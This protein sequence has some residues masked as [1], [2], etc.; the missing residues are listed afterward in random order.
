MSR[1][2]SRGPRSRVGAE[3]FG[4]PTNADLI[5]DRPSFYAVTNYTAGTVLFVASIRNAASF[6]SRGFTFSGWARVS[7]FAKVTDGDDTASTCNFVSTSM[8]GGDAAPSTSVTISVNYSGPISGTITATISGVVDVAPGVEILGR[9]SAANDSGGSMEPRMRFGLAW[10]KGLFSGGY[11]GARVVGTEDLI[12]FA[13]CGELTTW[14][15]NSRQGT[16]SCGVTLHDT[17]TLSAGAARDY[18]FVAVAGTQPTTS[19]DP[20]AWIAAHANDFTV[21]ITSRTGSSTGAMGNLAFSLKTAIATTT[22]REIICNTKRFMRVK[23]WQKVSGE[24]HL[25]V[26]FHLDFWLNGSDTP[27]D[28]EFTALPKM[29][30]VTP[31]PFGVTQTKER[32]TYT[33]TFKYGSTTLDTRSS[34]AHYYSGWWASLRSADD[35]HHARKH[36]IQLSDNTVVKPKLCRPVYDASTLK[37][38]M[39]VRVIPPVRLGIAYSGLNSSANLTYTPLTAQGAQAALDA[40]GPSS[41]RGIVTDEECRLIS[42]QGLSATIAK[43]SWRRARVMGQADLA[44]PYHNLDHRTASGVNGGTDTT[45]RHIPMPFRKTAVVGSQS[46]AGLAT[47]IVFS[48]VAYEELSGLTSLPYTAPVGGTGPWSL[49]IN[50]SHA[51][52]YAGAIAF[53][54]GETYLADATVSQCMA[55]VFKARFNS[56]NTDRYGFYTNTARGTAVGE[57]TSGATNRWGQHI[58]RGS[59]SQIRGLGFAMLLT[60]R[61]WMLRGDAHPEKPLLRNMALNFS[62]HCLASLDLYPDDVRDFGGAFFETIYHGATS[63]WMNTLQGQG[64]WMAAGIFDFVPAGARGMNAYEELYHLAGRTLLNSFYPYPYRGASYKTVWHTDANAVVPI[65]TDEWP[66]ESQCSFSGGLATITRAVF[67]FPFANDDTVRFIAFN[68]VFS[69]QALPS[70][71]V[72][73]QKYYLVNVNKSLNTAQVAATPGGTPIAVAD[74]A[75]CSAYITYESLKTVST[76]GAPYFVPADDSTMMINYALAELLFGTGHA[77]LTGTKR[78]AIRAAMVGK[79]AGISTYAAWNLDGNNLL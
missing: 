72:P 49:S 23:C 59:Q 78:D 68:N 4:Q 52:L 63:W 64:A 16:A 15:D 51:Y 9:V 79:I 65:G 13:S 46:Y 35:E 26:E 45:N 74:V 40:Q 41:G 70:P 61:A 25:I 47:P 1:R 8:T 31:T 18:E 29:H 67:G 73:Y 77:D 20:W 56:L 12:A 21:D 42:E 30:W 66:M 44:L 19:F 69:A 28:I 60:A 3:N 55:G 37:Q 24:E 22:R 34:L 7:G 2:T 6:A 33:A 48:R 43:Q 76:I 71:L 36:W 54:E 57:P 27:T 17:N 50:N 53:L 11:I 39:Q 58:E 75:S 32:Q 10:P 62:G 5:F 14:S 38:M